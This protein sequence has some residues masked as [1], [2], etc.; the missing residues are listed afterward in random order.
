[1]EDLFK[2]VPLT[3][4]YRFSPSLVIYGADL[5]RFLDH[6]IPKIQ[7]MVIAQVKQ[8]MPM[9]KIIIDGDEP[10]LE[11]WYKG[12]IKNKFVYRREALDNFSP[13]KI[14]SRFALWGKSIQT[15]DESGDLFAFEEGD[16]DIKIS[17]EASTTTPFKGF[18]KDDSPV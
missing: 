1:M 6:L 4:P 5:N 16:A 18:V 17:V 15:S 10:T 11:F 14:V 13:K 3:P 8:R 9:D 12:G 7:N 2:P